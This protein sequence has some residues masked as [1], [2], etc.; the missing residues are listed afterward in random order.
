MSAFRFDSTASQSTTTQS[1]ST[2]NKT[3]SAVYLS[4]AGVPLHRDI[5]IGSVPPHSIIEV[6]VEAAEYLTHRKDAEHL[7]EPDLTG[8]DLL[9]YN[10]QQQVEVWGQRVPGTFVIGRLPWFVT[11]V[12]CRWNTYT[13]AD[14]QNGSEVELPL[15]ADALPDDVGAALR[16][17]LN[18]GEE[19]ITRLSQDGKE[20]SRAVIGK[21]LRLEYVREVSDKI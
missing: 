8:E 16:K 15:E 12:V 10:K 6:T 13:F 11:L 21:D 20:L 19:E 18:L 9:N 4:Y 3:A 7:I 2:V 17:E 1:H 14:K 5:C